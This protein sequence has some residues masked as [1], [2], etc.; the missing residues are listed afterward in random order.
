MYYNIQGI[1]GKPQCLCYNCIKDCDR[2]DGC[3]EENVINHCSN[4]MPYKVK[5]TKNIFTCVFKRF[6]NK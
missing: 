5:K 6:F 1:C 3:G 4:Y 2:C